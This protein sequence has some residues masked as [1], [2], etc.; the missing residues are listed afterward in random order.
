[1]AYKIGY[2]YGEKHSRTYKLSKL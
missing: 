1:M 2:C